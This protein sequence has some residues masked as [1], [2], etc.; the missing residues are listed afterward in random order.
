MPYKSCRTCSTN[1]MGS[2]SCHIMPLVINSLGVD[3]QT[4]IYMNRGQNQFLKIRCMPA[5]GRCKPR[6]KALTVVIWYDCGVFTIVYVTIMV[7]SISVTYGSGIV[8]HRWE[9]R[10][11]RKEETIEERLSKLSTSS[12]KSSFVASI[13][14]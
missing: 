8:K 3:T 1:H 5:S 13:K 10:D 14:A 6:L 4:H 11:A 2:I 7:V 12:I 9:I